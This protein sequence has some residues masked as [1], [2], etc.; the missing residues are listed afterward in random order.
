MD[1]SY[2]RRVRPIASRVAGRYRVAQLIAKSVEELL[3]TD[4]SPLPLEV[5]PNHMG[6]NLVSVEGLSW[7]RQGDGQLVSLTV[8][9]TPAER[10]AAE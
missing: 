8:H 4:D 6:I 9:F 5:I 2:D 10:K 1:H 7:R 3:E